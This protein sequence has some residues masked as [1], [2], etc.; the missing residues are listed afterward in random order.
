MRH[1]GR[2]AAMGSEAERGRVPMWSAPGAS[3]G[4]AGGRVGGAVAVVEVVA[5]GGGGL[6][7]RV[8]VREAPIGRL[9]RPPTFP[10]AAAAARLARDGTHSDAPRRGS[11]PSRHAPGAG[12]LRHAWIL[13]RQRLRRVADFRM[14]AAADAGALR[15]APPVV[16]AVARG[17]AAPTCA[18][19]RFPGLD[20]FQPACGR[21]EAGP[22]CSGPALHNLSVSTQVDRGLGRER[23]GSRRSG[24]EAA[25]RTGTPFSGLFA[26]AAGTRPHPAR[27][28]PAS[29]FC[30]KAVGDGG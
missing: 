1:D 4:H 10:R 6:R 22:A 5:A 20:P 9:D 28:R 8:A 17:P 14:A 16:G 26:R 2:N 12:G 18:G 30:P 3:L 19:T 23:S 7:H 13:R 25:L 15:R 29:A 27:Q 24:A 11:D 21:A